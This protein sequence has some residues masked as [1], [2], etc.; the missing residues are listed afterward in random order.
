MS[1]ATSSPLPISPSR[2]T[3]SA[4][5][6]SVATS[7]LAAR[8]ASSALLAERVASSSLETI[9]STQNPSARRGATTATLTTES[10]LP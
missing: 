3:L 2:N 4:R 8:A 5:A 7:T 9:E 10:R 1:E 6:G